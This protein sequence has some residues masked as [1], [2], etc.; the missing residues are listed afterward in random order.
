MSATYAN[1]KQ[2]LKDAI[3]T[4]YSGKNYSV[5]SHPPPQVWDYPF[6]DSFDSI[7]KELIDPI[8]F[9]ATVMINPQFYINTHTT[10]LSTRSQK[11]LLLSQKQQLLLQQHE[12]LREKQRIWDDKKYRLDQ[13]NSL[14]NQANTGTA[15]P[16]TI[17]DKNI[18][19][20]NKDYTTIMYN[21]AITNLFKTTY[22]NTK[23]FNENY[24]MYTSQAAT[25]QS[26]I[27]IAIQNA[28][29]EYNTADQELQQAKSNIIQTTQDI[30][31][32]QNDIVTANTAVTNSKPAY[33]IAMAPK[34]NYPY[35]SSRY[36]ETDTNDYYDNIIPS[37]TK[38]TTKNYTKL[39]EIK[40]WFSSKY[41][42]SYITRNRDTDPMWV[43][44]YWK[45]LSI[46]V[47]V[48]IRS[49][50]M[51]WWDYLSHLD[52]LNGKITYYELNKYYQPNTREKRYV[53]KSVPTYISRFNEHEG[54]IYTSNTTN[55]VAL[56][57]DI[58]ERSI[59][60]HK[61][62][63]RNITYEYN[64]MNGLM[65]KI[66]TNSDV[67]NMIYKMLSSA[68]LVPD[69]DILTKY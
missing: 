15:I 62:L 31:T 18:V 26:D 68:E 13:Y 56:T 52:E 10:N 17:Y 57:P 4:A 25:L 43:G 33:D 34:T 45:E 29:N 53:E 24:L 64:C 2:R 23:V 35:R 40:R 41:Y 7:Q 38:I 36:I 61:S 67:R 65:E 6:G 32:T 50:G 44:E 28:Q 58:R 3:S 37:N 12:I 49:C 9:Y 46:E 66:S 20:N 69:L 19:I 47:P 16:V 51:S 8:V 5:T 22:P 60:F 21:I 11:Q 59:Y 1:V 30:Q 54:M 42:E 27:A 39:Y 14:K 55:T 63:L 48:L